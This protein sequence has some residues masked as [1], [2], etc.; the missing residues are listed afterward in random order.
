MVY[1]PTQVLKL[2]FSYV[3]VAM[4]LLSSSVFFL[5]GTGNLKK[6]EMF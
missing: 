1:N 5:A 6:F 2:V 4:L 3:S